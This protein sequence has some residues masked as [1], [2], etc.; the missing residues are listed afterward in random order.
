MKVNRE[1]VGEIRLGLGCGLNFE[2]ERRE[3]EI[4]RMTWMKSFSPYL[5]TGGKEGYC[6]SHEYKSRDWVIFVVRSQNPRTLF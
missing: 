1:E 3:S 2:D 5:E 4:G 6:R